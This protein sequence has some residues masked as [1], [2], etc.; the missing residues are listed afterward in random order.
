MFRRDDDAKDGEVSSPQ[1]ENEEGNTEAVDGG[2]AQQL[3]AELDATTARHAEL[4]AR[5]KGKYAGKSRALTQK[6]EEL[7]ALRAQLADTQ[8]ELGESRAYAEKIAHDKMS[9]L[10]DLLYARSKLEQMK[11]KTSWSVSHLEEK[12]AEHY[13][14]LQEFKERMEKTLVMYEEKLRALSIEYDEELYP[15]LMSVIAE[16]RYSYSL[17][18]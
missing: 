12:R 1:N 14:S 13:A 6:E 4:V 18:S 7:V 10:A 2:D 9:I 5:L 16:R 8:V 3:M 11:A 17:V 15:H